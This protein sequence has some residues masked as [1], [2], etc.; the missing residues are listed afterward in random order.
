MEYTI[1]GRAIENMQNAY[2]SYGK[3]FTSKQINKSFYSITL[4]ELNNFFKQN[5]KLKQFFLSIMTNE[6][7]KNL[8]NKKQIEKI[9]I[10]KEYK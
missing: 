1:P 8:P 4:D 3:F 7:E 5:F 2:D 10:K 6:D 9:F